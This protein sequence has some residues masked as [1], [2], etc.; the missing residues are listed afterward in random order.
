[1]LIVIISNSI[2]FTDYAWHD[3][4]NKPVT[5][6]RYCDFTPVRGFGALRLV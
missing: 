3:K 1:M 4:C 2:I 5:A 6:V